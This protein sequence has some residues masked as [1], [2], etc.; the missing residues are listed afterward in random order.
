MWPKVV[1]LVAVYVIQKHEQFAGARVVPCWMTTS[2]VGQIGA[3]PDINIY[4]FIKK[5]PIMIPTRKLHQTFL[6]L[7]GS[8]RDLVEPRWLDEP[9][10]ER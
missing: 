4:I 8:S 9:P 10:P 3:G 7:V 2:L 1:R 6:P 5:G